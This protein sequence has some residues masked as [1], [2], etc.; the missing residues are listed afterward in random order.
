V[1]ICVCVFML[2]LLPGMLFL[3][4]EVPG[5]PVHSSHVERSVRYNIKP[6]SLHNISFTVQIYRASLHAVEK[7]KMSSP[8][9]E[10]NNCS[11]I[12]LIAKCYS[13]STVHMV[14]N[15]KNKRSHIIG[16]CGMLFRFNWDI[17]YVIIN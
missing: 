3:I 9:K 10:S 2:I 17:I 5:L 14:P 15:M 16:S 13:N 11:V 4:P 8:C 6:F 1:P 7:R 12:Q